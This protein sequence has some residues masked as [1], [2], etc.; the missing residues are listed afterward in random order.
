MRVLIFKQI[1]LLLALAEKLK[2]SDFVCK[3]ACIEWERASSG[4]LCMLPDS[5][6][7]AARI[8][9]LL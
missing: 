5:T 8:L 1:A 7:A 2:V 3:K 6:C 4:K 9:R